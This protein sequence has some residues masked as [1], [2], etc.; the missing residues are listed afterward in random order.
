MV[1]NHKINTVIV[2]EK[3]IGID[4]K[5]SNFIK[6]LLTGKITGSVALYMNST[7]FDELS[8]I[9]R[10]RNTLIITKNIST[11]KYSETVSDSK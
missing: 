7:G 3:S 1:T 6:K 2:T 10:E 4:W 5:N 8:V 9:K 11:D